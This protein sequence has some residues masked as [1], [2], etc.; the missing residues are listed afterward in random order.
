MNHFDERVESALSTINS[1]I[2][3]FRENFDDKLIYYDAYEEE[4]LDKVLPKE[5]DSQKYEFFMNR[6]QFYLMISMVV[7]L[8]TLFFLIYVEPIVDTLHWFVFPILIFVAYFLYMICKY[9]ITSVQHYNRKKKY[10]HYWEDI[11]ENCKNHLELI[12]TILSHQRKEV[13]HHIAATKVIAIEEIQ[14]HHFPLNIA[15]TLDENNEEYALKVPVYLGSYISEKLE[16][17]FSVIIERSNAEL[18]TIS[19]TELV[20]KKNNIYFLDGNREKK[21]LPKSVLYH[22]YYRL[23]WEY[24]LSHKDGLSIIK[25][26]EKQSQ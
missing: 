6:L 20:A 8:P 7:A 5:K 17:G 16:N 15:Y 4:I 9:I 25:G 12:E 24:L 2:C 22:I 11:R 13:N 19:S 26:Y 14:H 1:L 21:E 18:R 3:R 10:K 23:H